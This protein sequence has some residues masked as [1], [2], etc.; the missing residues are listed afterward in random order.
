MADEAGIQSAFYLLF[1]L[2]DNEIKGPMPNEPNIQE[3][4]SSLSS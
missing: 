4:K 2:S 1:I 3:I